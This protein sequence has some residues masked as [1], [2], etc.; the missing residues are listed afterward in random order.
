MVTTIR[1]LARQLGIAVVAEGIE[2]AAQLAL[3]RG[4]GCDYAQGYFIS[5][6]VSATEIETLLR[7]TPVWR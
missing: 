2:S 6:P 5:E 7:A 4:I 3:V 1:E